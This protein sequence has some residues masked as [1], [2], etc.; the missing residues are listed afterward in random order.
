MCRYFYDNCKGF[1]TENCILRK[2]PIPLEEPNRH[3]SRNTE[4]NLIF[5]KTLPFFSFESYNTCHYN[6]NRQ[7]Y[8]H[9][10]WTPE[11]CMQNT[12]CVNL[13]PHK[14]V[15]ALCLILGKFLERPITKHPACHGIQTIWSSVVRRGSNCEERRVAHYTLAWIDV[16][17]KSPIMFGRGPDLYSLLPVLCPCRM[18]A[19][20]ATLQRSS[21]PD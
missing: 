7:A 10:P 21:L 9:T 1:I 20:T 3:V 11:A 5:C 8:K 17:N 2:V 14:S 16:I 12:T 15:T 19:H 13:Q 6:N 4:L 18:C